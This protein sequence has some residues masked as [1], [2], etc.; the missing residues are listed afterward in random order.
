MSKNGEGAGCRLWVRLLQAGLL[1][2]LGIL[3]WGTCHDSSRRTYR[4][5]I[6]TSRPS[7]TVVYQA[8]TENYKRMS[9][10]LENE[11]GGIEQ[12]DTGYRF[13]RTFDGFDYG[14]FAYLSAQCDDE[15]CVVTCRILV[16]GVVWRE[17]TSSGSYVIASCSGRLG[18][19]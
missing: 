4:P 19:D 12:I 3:V 18:S 1:L 13:E 5:S 9:L 8:E 16:N 14:D 10:T 7:L 6:S 15:Y 17:S 2:L 11:Q